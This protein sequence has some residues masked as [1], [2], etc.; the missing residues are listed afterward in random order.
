MAQ[1]EAMATRFEDMVQQWLESLFLA[2]LPIPVVYNI[3]DACVAAASRLTWQ[4]CSRTVH[5]GS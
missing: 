2:V 5:A 3:V 1:D 4:R